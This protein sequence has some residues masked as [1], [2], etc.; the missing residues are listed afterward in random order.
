MTNPD[1]MTQLRLN[2]DAFQ[3]P[4]TELRIR[5]SEI[6]ATS[7]M[8]FLLPTGELSID[9]NLHRLVARNKPVITGDFL[10]ST[11]SISV[12]REGTFVAV[13]QSEGSIALYILSYTADSIEAT[14][15]ER[16]I[17]NGSV[18]LSAIS[19][20]HYLLLAATGETIA[21]FDIGTRRVLAPIQAGFR[22]NCLDVDDYAGLVI[23]GGYSVAGVWTVSGH[24]LCEVNVDSP[25]SCVAVVGLPESV[26]GRFF[27]TGHASGTVA[28][29][30]VNYV[31]MQIWV[32]KA[33]RLAQTGITRV[34][35]EEGAC[36][37]L[38]ATATDVFCLDSLGSGSPSL[39]RR[40]ALECGRCATAFGQGQA[41]VCWNCHK[42][43]CGNCLPKDPIFAGK[44]SKERM[45]CSTCAS[46]PRATR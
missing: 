7:G 29:W 12:S 31:E 15:I 6:C 24:K 17:T 32:M 37:V 23:V 42:F 44:V 18:A 19:S 36:R 39:N 28:F 22:V 25:V 16:F 2:P 41:K 13:G 11:S 35:V 5:Q 21:R 30:G 27:V 9:S 8:S 38:A 46:Q 14:F 10:S 1:S 4:I 26:E 45:I 43:F 40:Y 33:A 20:V 34:E 3:F